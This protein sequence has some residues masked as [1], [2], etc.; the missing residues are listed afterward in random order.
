MSFVLLFGQDLRTAIA[1]QWCQADQSVVSPARR[2]GKTF[3]ISIVW[4]LPPR[5]PQ[6]PPNLLPRTHPHKVLDTP[7]RE[8]IQGRYCG[9]G[10]APPTQYLLAAGGGGARGNSIC[11]LSRA[12]CVL[13][14]LPLIVVVA[15]TAPVQQIQGRG[16]DV[17]AR[18]GGPRPGS[19]R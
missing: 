19:T 12:L 9:H 13:V 3:E 15:S 4:V 2:Q 17:G 18:G 11:K 7:S 10:A 16:P 8:Q 1:Q 14:C 6:P 5:S